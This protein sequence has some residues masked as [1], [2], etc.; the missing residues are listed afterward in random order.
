MGYALHD[1]LQKKSIE[2]KILAPSKIPITPG[3]IK[4]DRRD[5]RKI[6]R[7]LAYN[8]ASYVYVPD[9]QDKSIRDYLRLREDA[10]LVE[11]KYKQ[12]V[13]AFC[14]QNGFHYSKPSKWTKAHVYWLNHL[15]MG[16]PVK[17]E[18][19]KEYM[20][21]LEDAQRKVDVYDKRII[22][23][24][25]LDRYS[26][27]V[28]ELQCLIGIKDLSAITLIVETGDFSRF[29]TPGQYAAFTGLVPGESSS[30][31]NVNRLSITKAGNAHLRTT[32]VEAAQSYSRGTPGHK[33][34]LLAD[35]QNGNREEV[36]RYADH[37]NER[38]QRKYWRTFNKSGKR[39]IAVTAVARELAC[40]VWG[41][42][43]DHLSTSSSDSKGSN[44]SR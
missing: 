22:D 24:C 36:I 27:K 15:D 19:L 6:A 14:L 20:V 33:S 41:I 5:S 11:K 38:L 10:K 18:T 32:L 34:K 44:E 40:Y 25:S 26:R 30:S 43:T 1:E 16:D 29:A 39:N 12:R 3:E 23:F 35:R 8:L 2:C 17:N 37:A 21:F 7:C 28:K 9:L 31:D 13:N 4:T 42:M